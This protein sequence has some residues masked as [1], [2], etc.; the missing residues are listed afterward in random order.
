MAQEA[1]AQ[2][3]LEWSLPL[4]GRERSISTSE[5]VKRLKTLFEKLVDLRQDSTDASSCNHVAKDLVTPSL[6]NHRDRGV[7]ILVACCLAEILRIYAPEAPY[8]DD[9]IKAIFELFALQLRAIG[10]VDDAY[11][12]YYAHL[13]TSLSVIRSITLATELD[14]ADDLM[15][16]FFSTLLSKLSRAHPPALIQ[17]AVELM[18]VLIEE[19][20]SVPM[21]VTILLLEKIRLPETELAHA[22]AVQVARSAS[23]HLQ[24]YV[25]QYFTDIILTAVRVVH[26]GKATDLADLTDAHNLMVELFTVAPSLLLNVVP[27]LEEELVAEHQTFRSLAIKTLGAMLAHPHQLLF[28]LYP[29]AWKGWLNRRNDKVAQIRLQWLSLVPDVYNRHAVHLAPELN[30]ALTQRLLDVDEKVRLAACQIVPQIEFDTVRRF[31]TANV[32]DAIGSRIKDK[33]LSVRMEAMKAVGDLWKKVMEVVLPAIPA[34]GGATGDSQTQSQIGGVAEHSQYQLADTNLVD[35]EV[36]DLMAAFQWI[37]RDVL[38]SAYL[39]DAQLTAILENTLIETV[40]HAAKD[41]PKGAPPDWRAATQRLLWFLSATTDDD[42][43]N[44]AFVSVLTRQQVTRREMAEFL[45]VA[46]QYATPDLTQT[47]DARLQTRIQTLIASMAARLPDPAQGATVLNQVVKQYDPEWGTGFR[48]LLAWSTRDFKDLRKAAKDVLRRVEAVI[49]GSATVLG[50]IARRMTPFI[51]AREMVPHLLDRAV[52]RETGW[53]VRLRRAADALLRTVAHSFPEVVTVYRDQIVAV[54]DEAPALMLHLLAKTSEQVPLDERTTR[55][56]LAHAKTAECAGLVAT[57][58]ARN[59]NM[60]QCEDMLFKAVDVLEQDE[61]N[62]TDF[63]AALQHLVKFAKFQVD[64]YEDLAASAATPRLVRVLKTSYVA[65]V[66]SEWIDRDQLP[67]ETHGQVLAVKVLTNRVVALAKSPSTAALARETAVP[68]VRL[69]DKILAKEG[70]LVDD[71][72]PFAASALRHAAGRAFLRLAKTRELNGSG[73]RGDGVGVLPERL[74]L[75]WARLLEDPVQQVRTAL[76]SKV[77]TLLPVGQLPPR[78]LP[79]LCLV[80]NDPDA[81]LRAAMGAVLK[82]LAGA[83]QLQATHVVELALPRLLHILAHA[84]SFRSEI[85]DAK[86]AMVYVDMY[87]DAVL[88]ADRVAALLHLLTRTKQCRTRIGDDDDETAR[89]DTNMY[90]LAD[91]TTKHVRDRCRLHS[92][93]LAAYSGSPLDVPRDILAPLPDDEAE[94]NARKSYL[95]EGMLATANAAVA[96]G[97]G[98][99]KRPSESAAAGGR[100]PKRPK[101]PRKLKAYERVETPTRRSS[102]RSTARGKKLVEPDS[103]EEF[104]RGDDEDQSGSAGEEEEEEDE[105]AAMDAFSH[106]E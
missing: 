21:D 97:A 36:Q 72:P 25:C 13:L 40:V 33:R 69:L 3:R 103:D 19:S 29:G 18:T 35:D 54:L 2:Q 9:Q 47:V 80:A 17:Y 68:V 22:M 38:A 52:D 46:E 26:Q 90:L 49:P 101:T 14:S 96:A 75:R 34:A 84:P 74:Y 27:Q 65:D 67:A 94:A 71:L 30:E 102:R 20:A 99:R 85:D 39:N 104:E 64:L 44:R 81:T 62:P 10:N 1:P 32:F 48:A 24:K 87:L 31:V 95:P 59:G 50:L 88:R 79:V 83:P 60:P 93:P 8:E 7:R 56:V 11:H 6:L 63:V 41:T 82:M 73:P 61:P 105:D 51:V 45:T 16:D 28:R 106:V 58:V 43:A 66:R 15:L 86:L 12:A 4:V 98:A 77:K 23:D 70:K 55:R 5:L 53:A 37:P 57:I 100:E 91:L 42:R 76:V 92:W 78:F 89:V